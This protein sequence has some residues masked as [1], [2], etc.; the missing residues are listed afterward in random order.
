MGYQNVNK[1]PK[2][3]GMV[4]EEA[5]Y[6]TWNPESLNRKSPIEFPPPSPGRET[7]RGMPTVLPARPVD[8]SGDGG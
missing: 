2:E 7:G 8:F 6:E 3:P 1:K 4:D 5:T